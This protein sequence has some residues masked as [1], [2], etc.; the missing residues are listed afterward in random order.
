MAAESPPFVLQNG[1]HS[2]SL[3]REA[4]ASLLN[5][6]GGVVGLG[7]L[8]VT[9]NGTPNMTVNVA[10][11]EIW[12]PGTAAPPTQGAYFCYNDATVSLAISAAN[13]TNP[14]IDK[15]CAT[16]ED[17]AYSGS[18]NDWKLQVVTGTPTAGATLS[19]LN[20]AAATPV[21]SL[22]IC[23]VLVPASATTIVTADLLDNRIFA[24]P[25][26]PLRGNPAGSVYAV[27]G[28]LG[29]SVGDIFATTAT[30]FLRG[31]MTKSTH[32][33]TVPVAGVYRVDACCWVTQGG[34][35]GQTQV[36]VADNGTVVLAGALDGS[37]ASGSSWGFNVS[38][39]VVCAAGDTLTMQGI[40]ANGNASLASLNAAGYNFI[41]ASLES[42]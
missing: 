40:S 23:Y 3:F 14:R 13:A 41:S 35:G 36:Y 39:L 25:N 10:A 26:L 24:A 28:G 21:E 11:G 19:N 38:G 7:D 15:V 32:G 2:A 37:L 34:S 12:V 31:G 33:I 1:S 30:T 6:A 5:P 17:A 4:L 20:G 27:T 42:I 22:V 8:A 9:Q 29:T 16:V 18:N